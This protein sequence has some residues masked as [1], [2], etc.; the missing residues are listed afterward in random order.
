M[1]AINL[2]APKQKISEVSA[3]QITYL[4]ALLSEESLVT[5]NFYRQQLTCDLV[6][7]LDFRDIAVTDLSRARRSTRKRKVSISSAIV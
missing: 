2:I 5:A 4:L 3:L 7:A 6:Q 1:T